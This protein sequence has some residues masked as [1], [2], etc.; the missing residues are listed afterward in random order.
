MD[1]SFLISSI[2]AH[3]EFLGKYGGSS[4]EYRIANARIDH[5]C[6]P[7]GLPYEEIQH[8]RWG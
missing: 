2:E 5:Y 1:S 6:F 4:N 8:Y 3:P 7:R